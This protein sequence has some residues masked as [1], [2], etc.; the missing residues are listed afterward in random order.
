MQSIV[1]LMGGDIGVTSEAGV[2]ST[3]WFT[4]MLEKQNTNDLLIQGTDN[5]DVSVKIP[6]PCGTVDVAQPKNNVCKPKDEHHDVRILYAEDNVINQKVA[7]ILL[8]K[9]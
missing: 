6:V 1:Y 9:L 2:G 8:G 4:A 7:L 5:A 3:F